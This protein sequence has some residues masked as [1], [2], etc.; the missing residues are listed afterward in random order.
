MHISTITFKSVF[1][2][3]FTGHGEE[4]LV[5]TAGWSGRGV[6]ASIKGLGCL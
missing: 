6:K 2:R 4:K 1:D 5:W 3:K